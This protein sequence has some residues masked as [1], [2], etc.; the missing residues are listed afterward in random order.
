MASG[1]QVCSG[2]W[3]LLPMQAMKRAMAPQSSALLPA[4]LLTAHSLIPAIESVPDEPR[5]MAVPTSSPMSPTR[6]V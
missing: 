4:S 6:T 3:P 2:N 1:S 5:R